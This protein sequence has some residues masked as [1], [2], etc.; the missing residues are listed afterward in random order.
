MDISTK[1]CQSTTP[2]FDYL[3]RYVCKSALNPAYFLTWSRVRR[4]WFILRWDNIQTMAYITQIM[5]PFS[6]TVFATSTLLEMVF[7]KFT[8]P[9]SGFIP[10]LV[11]VSIK[12]NFVRCNRYLQSPLCFL[13]VQPQPYQL[14]LR[15]KILI[16]IWSSRLDQVK[17]LLRETSK[18]NRRTA[19]IS[20]FFFVKRCTLL[21]CKQIC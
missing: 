8:F 5:R 7:L 18:K 13:W 1:L 20:N 4:F 6:L 16:N 10:V 21:T 15:T 3:C 9:A 17:S 2:F 11:H 14:S 12:I 19:T